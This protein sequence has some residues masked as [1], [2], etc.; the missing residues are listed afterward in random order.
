MCTSGVTRYIALMASDDKT[1]VIISAVGVVIGGLATVGHVYATQRPRQSD[2][3][4]A[5]SPAS[6]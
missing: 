3:A 1:W 2:K 4:S 5:R 6:Q